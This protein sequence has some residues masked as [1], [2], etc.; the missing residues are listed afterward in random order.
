MEPQQ[1]NCRERQHQRNLPKIDVA[2][3][4]ELGRA[5]GGHGS[6][7]GYVQNDAFDAEVWNAGDKPH[8]AHNTLAAASAARCGCRRSTSVKTN[9][10][11]QR[12]SS[13]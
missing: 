5:R 9:G 8:K 6:L 3:Q 4:T 2:L 1:A 11:S 10:L 12:K 7:F 13:G